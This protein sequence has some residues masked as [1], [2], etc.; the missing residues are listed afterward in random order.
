VTRQFPLTLLKKIIRA[1]LLAPVGLI[2]LFEEWG[3]EPLAR[4]FAM[5]ARH[6]L[7]GAIERR[8]TSLP[9]W[10]AL[11]A[12]GVPVLALVPIKLLALYLFAEGHVA[13]GL[14]LV[15]AAKLV[16]TALAA[17][18]FQLTE[19]ALL[20]ISWFARLYLPWK[21][22]KDRLLT[23]LR[24]SAQWFWLCSARDRAKLCCRRVWASLKGAVS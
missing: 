17:R 22:W 10:A 19:P 9:P 23:Q 5:L 13:I 14:G 3:W 7:W 4:T 1:L 24:A 6:R 21:R 15:I 8:I 18:L 2:L 11:L 16:G 12:F 20:Q